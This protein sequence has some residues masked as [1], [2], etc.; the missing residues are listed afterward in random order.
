MKACPESAR[1]CSFKLA[2]A[3]SVIPR[4]FG[5]E[6]KNH[7]C[8]DGVGVRSQLLDPGVIREYWVAVCDVEQRTAL[9]CGASEPLTVSPLL[10]PFLTKKGEEKGKPFPDKLKKD[11]N[12]S[13]TAVIPPAVI[14]KGRRTVVIFV[15]IFVVLCLG[16]SGYPCTGDFDTA[17]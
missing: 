2:S 1:E 14:H 13:L 4:A 12:P 16:E 11:E 5:S 3:W 9:L 10:C 6:D 8:N 17:R 7:L 15:V